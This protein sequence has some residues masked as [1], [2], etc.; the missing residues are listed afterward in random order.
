MHAFGIDVGGTNIKAV[1]AS[2]TGEVAARWNR[3]TP[4]TGKVEDIIDA[5]ADLYATMRAESSGLEGVTELVPTVTVAVP[6]IVD[7]EHGVGVYS[8]NL[9]WKDYPLRDALATALQVPV[10]LAHDVRSG[11]LGESRWGAAEADSLYIALGTG[12]SAA[13]IIDG[14]P[15][16]AHPWSG[17][18][19]QHLVPDP[20]RPGQNTTSEKVCSASAFARRMWRA[21]PRLIAEDAGARE[22]FDLARGGNELARHIISSGLGELSRSIAAAI[23][24]LGPI[25]VVVG[26]GMAGAG[27]LPPNPIAQQLRSYSPL[28]PEAPLRSATLGTYS[29]ALGAAVR[30]FDSYVQWRALPISFPAVD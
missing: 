19:G 8:V 25:P 16:A 1:L 23:H 14:Y 13:L 9:G 7:E 29:Q 4:R 20:D 24:L 28:L 22:V 15:V 30:S 26:G 5:L 12:V 2:K 10:V 21:D 11:A 27:P 3:P 18:I 6:G 17:E